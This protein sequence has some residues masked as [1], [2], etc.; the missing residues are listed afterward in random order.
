[1]ESL[2]IGGR[3]RIFFPVEM[4]L[5]VKALVTF[6]GVGKSLDP[7]LNI[8]QISRRHIFRIYKRHFSP[9][10]LVNQFM[11][12][13]PE[14][15]DVAVHLPELLADSS[16]FWDRTVNTTP[17]EN[18]LAGL[19]SSLIAGACIVGGVIALVQGG[20]P[21]VWIILFALGLIL[22]VFGK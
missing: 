7:N 22:A 2:S 1:V 5:M 18:P 15:I 17:A 8:P 13:M 20:S 19:R 9:E 12:G 3:Y 14:L 11:Q 4:T 10:N 21:V 6:E 16:R